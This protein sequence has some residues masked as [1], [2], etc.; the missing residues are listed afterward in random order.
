MLN[1]VFRCSGSAFQR[2]EFAK[3]DPAQAPEMLSV[4]YYLQTSD[5]PTV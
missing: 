5:Q 2:S 4:R 1:S 3:Y